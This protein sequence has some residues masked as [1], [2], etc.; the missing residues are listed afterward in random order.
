MGYRDD[1]TALE[2]RR[3]VLVREIKGL[4]ADLTRLREEGAQLRQAVR[5]KRLR[6]ALA[7]ARRWMTRHPKTM[8]FFALVLGVVVLIS[9]RVYQERRERRLRLEAA[10]GKGCATR[11]K[12]DAS[13][14]G[15]RVLVN[16]TEVGQV[17]LKVPIC[18]GY[19]RVQ[20]VHDRALPWQRVVNVGVQPTIELQASLVPFWPH[21]RPNGVLVLSD[22]P[23]SIVFANGIEV[24]RTP[25]LLPPDRLDKQLHLALWSG[26]AT[27]PLQLWNGNYAHR[28]LWFHMG[29]KAEATR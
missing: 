4:E 26:A 14:R 8:V 23:G 19:Y 1:T 5:R 27:T 22:P 7:R 29:R 28:G 11:L 16:G 20:V 24:G 15:A 17:P 9:V 3:E 25:V 12:V 6:L 2:G 13:L 21:E 18:R 10:L